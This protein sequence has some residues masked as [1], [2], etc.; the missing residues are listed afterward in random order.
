MKFKFVYDIFEDNENAFIVLTG[1][2]TL[3]RTRTRD[4][5]YFSKNQL[6]SA[7]WKGYVFYGTV[8]P[9]ITLSDLCGR[10]WQ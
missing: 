10:L 9:K 1:K 3:L 5:L 2:E 8:S 7:Y 4:L 6:L